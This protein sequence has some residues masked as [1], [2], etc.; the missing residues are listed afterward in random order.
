MN[1][2]EEEILILDYF[3]KYFDNF[4]KGKLIKSES[5]DFILQI[6]PKNTIGIELTRLNDTAPTLKEKIEHTLSNKSQKLK[7]YRSKNFNELWLI[8]HTDSI[9]ESI[10]YNI[11]NKLINW[12]FAAKF[13]KVF[14]FD[15]FSKK[16]YKL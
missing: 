10:T 14:L 13:K 4:P 11:Q 1:Q 8:I 5:P 15:L 2:Q 9:D 16:I 12:E 7:L 6:N 3:R